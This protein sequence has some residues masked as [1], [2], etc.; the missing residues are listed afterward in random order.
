MN[1][2]IMYMWTS[3]KREFYYK[4]NIIGMILTSIFVIIIQKEL[5]QS[6][7]LENEIING[8]EYT[9]IF[10]YLVV[11]M[12][13]RK[14]LGSGIDETIS[15]DFQ[16]GKIAIDLLRPQIYFLKVFFEDLGR[17]LVHFTMIGF[18][19]AIYF[20]YHIKYLEFYS[21]IIVV[22][23]LVSSVLAY[24]IFL[25]M[26]FCIGL[27]S[28]WFGRSVGLTM[29]KTG[30]FS[31]LGGTFIPV[32]FYP[33]WLQRVVSFLPFKYIYYSPISFLMNKTT[34]MQIIQT[35]SIQC[36]WCIFFAMIGWNMF[37]MGNK[38]IVIQGG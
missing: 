18:I 21:T 29:I 23:I 5:W 12:V 36:I 20:L 19:S 2:Y 7:Y 35:L 17:G 22:G 6:I 9:E 37:K 28:I 15:N 13:F 32:D 33:L 27:T 16:S 3:I 31:L 10:T 24:F 26:N 30:L 4:V 1:K 34:T 14:F 38:R 11:G 8:I 25:F